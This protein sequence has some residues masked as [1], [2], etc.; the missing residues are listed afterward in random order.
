M[1]F[2]K[3]FRSSLAKKNIMFFFKESQIWFGYESKWILKKGFKYNFCYRKYNAF[4][5]ENF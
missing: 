1:N 2:E 5:K 3:D 4:Y